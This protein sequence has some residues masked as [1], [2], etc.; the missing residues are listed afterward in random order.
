MH[1]I[2]LIKIISA[3]VIFMEELK[4]L[5]D[6]DSIWNYGINESTLLPGSI[7]RFIITQET[8]AIQICLNLGCRS[9]S[10]N[11]MMKCSYIKCFYEVHIVDVSS[12]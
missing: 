10:F 2:Y 8:L 7:T 9:L 12:R 1:R 3:L 11:E 4:L 5:S 6:K